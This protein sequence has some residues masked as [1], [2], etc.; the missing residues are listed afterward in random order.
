VHDWLPLVPHGDTAKHS[1]RCVPVCTLFTSDNGSTDFL[2]S[3][4]HTRYST[5]SSIDLVGFFDAD[6]AGCGIDRKSTSST[7]HFL[8]SS[9][10]F[11]GLRRNNLLLHNPP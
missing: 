5:S 9:P 3:Q 11:V 2:I 10:V 8:G 6:F 4:I 7:C 1:V